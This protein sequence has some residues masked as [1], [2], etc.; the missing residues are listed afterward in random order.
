M[1]LDK[2]ELGK[3]VGFV[4]KV[5]ELPGNEEFIAALREVVGDN[6][7]IASLEGIPSEQ[8]EEIY[9]YCIEKVLQ[10]QAEAFYADFPIT[11]LR[12][13]LIELFV[14][15][16]RSRREGEFTSFGLYVYEQIERIC[17]NLYSD[18]IK[19][20]FIDDIANEYAFAKNG[21][22]DRYGSR[23]IER[24]SYF[25]VKPDPK[26]NPPKAMLKLKMVLYF[27]VGKAC[28]I[29]WHLFND[30]RN[31]I[32]SIRNAHAHAGEDLTDNQL[33]ILSKKDYFYLPFQATLLKF[34]TLVTKSISEKHI[35]QV[36]DWARSLVA[37]EASEETT[38][39]DA[40]KKETTK[41]EMKLE[42]TLKLE[43]GFFA[44]NPQNGET[45]QSNDITCP[46][47]KNIGDT[48]NAIVETIRGT[49][50]ITKVL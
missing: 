42:I 14:Y 23:D 34:V 8:I 24:V 29:D 43:G 32:Y 46:K 40:S 3:V 33:Q 4:K 17:D 49:K 35:E 45:Y 48:I 25:I 2:K 28:T 6:N 22:D 21:F 15:M 1:G 13:K 12:S 19:S 11:E 44:K 26:N 7:T 20:E 16:E 38:K 50:K 47:D 36:R 18:L 9:E 31:N 27:F 37:K 30:I 39:V 5:K 41:E 10:K